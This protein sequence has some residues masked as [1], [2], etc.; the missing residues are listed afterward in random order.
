MEL[1]RKP[2]ARFAALFL[3]A[4][5]LTGVWGCDHKCATSPGAG[6]G[7][8]GPAGAGPALAS[9]A[10]FEILASSTVT[11]NAGTTVFGDVGV[12]TAGGLINGL[13][14]GQ[15]TGGTRHPGDAVALQAQNDVTPAY[16]DLAGRACNA[17][18]TGV[19]LGGLTLSGGVYCFS[20][21][22]QLT[23]ILTLDGLGNPDA[24]F[25]FKIGSGLTTASNSS[26]VLTGLAQAK[27]VWWQVTSSAVLGTNTAFQGNIIALASITLNTGTTITG[28]ALARTG[29]VTMDANAA[30]LP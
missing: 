24:V 18:L 28:R 27:N 19:D 1:L 22:A 30:T 26:V 10:S 11:A 14:V 3:F 6:G 29:A 20:S 5:L 17:V 4:A 13:P 21:T 16:N 23:G 25:V 9:A 2:T 7:N 8:P 15:P 12:S